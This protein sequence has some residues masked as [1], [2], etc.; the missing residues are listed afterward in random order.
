MQAPGLPSCILLPYSLP[1]IPRST[2]IWLNYYIIS[3]QRVTFITFMS[4]LTE[5]IQSMLKHV[6]HILSSRHT[7]LRVPFSPEKGYE[8]FHLLHKN[9]QE[10]HIGQFETSSVAAIQILFRC[11]S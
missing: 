8:L 2:T 3:L 5:M 7:A 11:Q 9:V 1:Q 10:L 4:D 6:K